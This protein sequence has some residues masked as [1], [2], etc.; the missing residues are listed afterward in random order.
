MDCG[1]QWLEKRTVE[2]SGW[3][4]VTA[5]AVAREC[6]KSRDGGAWVVRG[7][8]WRGRT[9]GAWAGGAVAGGQ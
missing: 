6:G 9:G 1:G 7:S 8:D 5:M 4:G 3:R 2:G